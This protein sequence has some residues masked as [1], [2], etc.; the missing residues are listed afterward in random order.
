MVVL[1]MF[2]AELKITSLCVT[3]CEWYMEL[4]RPEMSDVQIGAARKKLVDFKEHVVVAFAPVLAKHSN[5]KIGT[6]KMH[7]QT[8]FLDNVD[9]LG[10]CD[11][12]CVE[13]VEHGHVDVKATAAFTNNKLIAPQMLKVLQREQAMSLIAPQSS[14]VRL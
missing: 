3:L 10:Q 6:I 12:Y 8:H 4:R 5:G 14:S 1:G 9:W 11:E 2:P 7:A 13:G